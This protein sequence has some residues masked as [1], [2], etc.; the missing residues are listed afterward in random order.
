MKVSE[1][2][3]SALVE[4]ISDGIVILNGTLIEFG[5]RT[6]YEISGYCEE[7]LI[8]KT[9]DELISP[10]SNE[11]L[12]ERKRRRLASEPVPDTYELEIITK[13]GQKV[14]V[15]TKIQPI[16]YKGVSARIVIIRDMTKSKQA[17]NPVKESEQNLRTYLENAPDGIAQNLKNF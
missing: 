13:D 11:L 4:Q 2:K 1:K 16:V 5:N 12:L 15:E 3:Y 17:E 6:I 8:G 7:E 9:F 14:S 10:E